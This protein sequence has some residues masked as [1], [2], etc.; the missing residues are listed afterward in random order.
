M[1]IFQMLSDNSKLYP[2]IFKL[3]EVE[4]VSKEESRAMQHVLQ[5]KNYY[6]D[7]FDLKQRPVDPSWREDDFLIG[8]RDFIQQE[9]NTK[10]SKRGTGQYESNRGYCTIY[11]NHKSL[12]RTGHHS[13]YPEEEAHNT[14]RAAIP[15]IA[16][17]RILCSCCPRRMRR[18]Y[19]RAF[20]CK[21]NLV[22]QR[23]RPMR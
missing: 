14:N 21:P 22:Q 16:F 4:K 2:C 9:Q 18:R 19:Q 15:G 11:H 5:S 3:R 20:R 13:V 10:G 7:Y 1:S 8:V 6:N 23:K 12:A 17:T